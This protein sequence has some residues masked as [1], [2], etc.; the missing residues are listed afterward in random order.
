MQFYKQCRILK[1]RI[2]KLAVHN[3]CNIRVIVGKSVSSS[4]GKKSLWNYYFVDEFMS[5]F[6]EF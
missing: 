5:V 3:V 4:F 2:K 6:S 1:Q